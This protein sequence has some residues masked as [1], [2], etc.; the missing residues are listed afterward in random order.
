MDNQIV[1][2]NW[3]DL[4]DGEL[5]NT[6]DINESGKPISTK[7]ISPPG[8]WTGTNTSGNIKTPNC[9]DWTSS[10]TQLDGIGG[11]ISHIYGWTD[12]WVTGGSPSFAK[13]SNWHHLY[14]FEQ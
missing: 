5:K 6:I 2:N 8:A 11:S 1:A 14:C 13:C 12:A 7:G 10:S 9:A 3:A 4:T